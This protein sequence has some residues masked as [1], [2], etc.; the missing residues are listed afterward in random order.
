M[1]TEKR[2]AQGHLLS[3]ATAE[4][5]GFYDQGVRAFMLA[6]GDSMGAFDAAIQAAPEMA[7]AQLG[8][9][10][11]FVLSNDPS[12]TP[13]AAAMAERIGALKL[14]DREQAHCAALVHLANGRRAAGVAVLDRHLMHYPRDIMAHQYAAFMDGFLGRFPWMR[15]RS[16]RA[17]PF[18]SRDVPGYGA[19]LAVHGFGLEEAGDYARAEEESR[20]AAELEPYSW[21]PQHTVAHVM[22]MTGRPEDGIGWMAARESFWA[23]RDHSTQAHIWWHKAMFHMELG[24]Y[25]EA[26][27][28][29]DGPL[30]ATQKPLAVAL[31]NSSALLWRLAA[32]GHDVGDRWHALAELWEGHADGRT[33]AFADLHASMADLGAGRDA[34]A[35]RRLAAMRATAASDAEAAPTY[36]QVAIPIAEG[37]AAFQR[38]AYAQAVDRLLPIRFDL[39]RIGGSHAQRDVV[40]W[41][42]T[43]AA[44]RAGQRD[45]ALALAHERLGLRPRS[46]PNQAFLRQAEALAH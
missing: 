22:E 17:L 26:L 5:V 38:G 23:T 42:L 15:D 14:N 12:L 30:Q 31:T 18:W 11:N 34:S 7:A 27:A 29:H 19:M 24:Q 1:M 44:I 28:L 35:E 40:V 32:L 25:A 3:G 9:A 41:T 36:A 4:A 13:R 8:K 45:V 2:D 39:W 43:A 10:W 46:V 6:Y 37:L 21:W 33:L 20:A 16:A